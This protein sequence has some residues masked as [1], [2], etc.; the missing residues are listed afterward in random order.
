MRS[1]SD[2]PHLSNIKKLKGSEDAW[3]LRAGDYRILYEVDDSIGEITVYSAV[4]R[5]EAY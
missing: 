1:I 2:H 5:K 3:R 4:D